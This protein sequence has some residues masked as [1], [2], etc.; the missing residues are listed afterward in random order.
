[1]KYKNLNIKIVDDGPNIL[2]T[3]CGIYNMMKYSREQDFIT[4]NPDTFWSKENVEEIKNME[5]IYLKNKFKNILL[6]VNKKK[7]F[8]TNLKGDFN[9]SQNLL[10]KGENN[11]YIY[12]GCQIINRAIF[13]KIEKKIFSMNEIWNLSL[14]N[15]MLSGFESKEMF[16]HITNLEVYK[17]FLKKN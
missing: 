3:G 1:M 11:E 9:L 14:K 2:D 17:N 16:N 7:S 6:V 5:N 4:L 8:D 12:T 13:D 15:N 10:S